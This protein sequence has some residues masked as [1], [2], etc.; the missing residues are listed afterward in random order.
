MSKGERSIDVVNNV[1]L[2]NRDGNPVSL[3]ATS[4]YDATSS[5][6]DTVDLPTPGIVWVNTTGDIAIIPVGSDTAL[7]YTVSTTRELPI[8]AKR[9]LSTGTTVTEAFIW[10]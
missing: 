2:A 6:S 8:V 3:Q 1:K 10:H 5:F 7:T 9:I 4:H